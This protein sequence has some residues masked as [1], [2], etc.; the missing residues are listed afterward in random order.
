M[1]DQS[2]THFLNR[3]VPARS[4]HHLATT[5]HRLLCQHL[6]MPRPFRRHQHAF[7]TDLIQLLLEKPRLVALSSGIENQP[8]SHSGRL[9]A[10][11]GRV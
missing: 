4:H 11:Q 9:R 1:T 10:N 7:V 3:T 2:V 8:D 6:R 5:G